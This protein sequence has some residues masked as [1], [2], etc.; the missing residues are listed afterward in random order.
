M[1]DRLMYRRELYIGGRWVEPAG[2]ETAARRLPLDRGGRRRGPAGHRRRHRP[3]GRRSPHR[4]RRRP[5]A[6][7]GTRRAR[8]GPGAGRR[9]AAQ[10]G[11]RHRRASP[12]TRWAVAVSQ[13]TASQTG[14]VAP[15]FDYYAEL[16]R[17]F[18]FE[19][20][21]VT[22]DRAGL[23]TN[24][25]VGVV[26][27]IVPWNAP[28]TLS[29]W[30]VAPALAAGCT[31]VVKPPPE[32]PAEQLRARRGPRRGR[33]AGRRGQRRPRRPR[34]RRAPRHPPGHRQGRLHRIDRRGQADHEPVRR[35]GQAGLA[36]ARRQVGR[37]RAR[38]RR[39]GRRRP[40][41]G[42]CGA[43]TCRA[44]CAAPTP[45]C[46]CPARAT[47]RR[48]TPRP[49]RRRPSPTATRTTRPRSSARSSPSGSATGSRATSGSPSTPAPGWWPAGRARPPAE[50][51]VRAARRSSATST[52]RCGWPARRSSGP[53]CASSPTTTTTTPSA[54]PTTRSTACRAACGAPTTSVR[55]AVAR[56][57]RTGSVA[58]NGSYPPFPLVPFGGFKQ[59]GLGR[60]LGPEGLAA[61]LEPR[62]IG[63]PPSLA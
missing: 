14:L 13:A 24:E 22:A 17:T 55:S 52:T 56:R 48:S 42:G 35:A 8:R 45:A 38:R 33:R 53:C 5:V 36:R 4:V 15:V 50:G 7:H 2:T 28:V 41:G 58:V 16:I 54:S 62:S 21:V 11:G 37:R 9:P 30:K 26:A 10:A 1:D 31:V 27:A 18:E 3:G 63:L 61:Y 19:R 12:S 59:S 25:P 51:L 57:L 29:A 34:G 60:E 47:P 23:V 32:A 46:W 40:A 20:R 6:P 43:C 49:P 44:R 39:P